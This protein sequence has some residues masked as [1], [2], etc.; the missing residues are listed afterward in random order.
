MLLKSIH[1]HG[2]GESP[3]VLSMKQ[4]FKQLEKTS[5]AD[6]A[7]WIERIKALCVFVCVRAC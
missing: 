6:L 4:N 1:S 2:E 7:C 3:I 5:S